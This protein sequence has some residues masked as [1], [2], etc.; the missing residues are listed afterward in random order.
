MMTFGRW[1]LSWSCIVLSAPIALR[2]KRAGLI[3]IDSGFFAS[4]VVKMFVD[5]IEDCSGTSTLSLGF[6]GKLLGW[7]TFREESLRVLTHANP[8]STRP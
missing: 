2:V 6:R 3:G 5:P 1:T 7:L 4:R 8:Q